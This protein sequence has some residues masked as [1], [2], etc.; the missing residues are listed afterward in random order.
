VNG[1]S[2]PIDVHVDAEDSTDMLGDLLS[3]IVHLLDQLSPSSEA[4]I[5]AKRATGPPIA[6]SLQSYANVTVLDSLI[7]RDLVH[8]LE[9]SPNGRGV[10]LLFERRGRSFGSLYRSTLPLLSGGASRLKRSG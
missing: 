5:E 9:R 8:R 10:D 4:Q 1:S 7:R 3:D 2:S 6:L